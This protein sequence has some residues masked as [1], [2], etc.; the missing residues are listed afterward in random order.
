MEMMVLDL[1]AINETEMKELHKEISS[2]S[3]D[4]SQLI[5]FAFL[6]QLIIFIIIQFFEISSVFRD[7]HTKGTKK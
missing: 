2:L 1:E 4:E 6:L 3:E 7:A 5:L